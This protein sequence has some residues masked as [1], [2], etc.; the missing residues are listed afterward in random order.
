MFKAHPIMA[1]R[2]VE[3]NIQGTVLRSRDFQNVE[4]LP[5]E[6]I[7]PLCG[8]A[9]FAPPGPLAA[10]FVADAAAQLAAG[11]GSGLIWKLVRLDPGVALVF[12]GLLIAMTALCVWSA[13]RT[14]GRYKFDNRSRRVWIFVSLLLGPA[15]LLD[16]LAV[17]GLAGPRALPSVQPSPP[18]H[19]RSLPELRRPCSRTWPERDRDHCGWRTGAGCVVN[20][21]FMDSECGA[22]PARDLDSQSVASCDTI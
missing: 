4:Q 12:T 20:R 2:I 11:T 21:R 9:L 17:A 22:A 10:A 14:A 5:M 19:A 7:P 1:T 16:A 13:R 15:G 3:M 18:S 8:A 6:T